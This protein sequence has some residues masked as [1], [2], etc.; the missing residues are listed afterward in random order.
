MLNNTQIKDKVS[1]KEMLDKFELLSVNQLAAQ[2]KLLE[3]WKSVHIP[4]YAIVLEPYSK[5]R[6]NNTHDLRNQTKR[7]FND[8]AKLKIAAQSFSVDAAK[9]WN[10]A[11]EEV[12]KAA[13]IQIAKRAI[14]ILVKTFPI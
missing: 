6:P 10:Q 2:I 3:A 7:V 5:E 8:S 12:T 14:R 9:L 13:S 1:T 4:G 11:P